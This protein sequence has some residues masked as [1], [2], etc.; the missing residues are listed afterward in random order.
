MTMLNTAMTSISQPKVRSL[1]GPVRPMRGMV[2]GFDV[3]GTEVE[4]TVS[5]I[6]YGQ[7]QAALSQS[8]RDAGRAGWWRTRS[9]A[10]R[11]R[12]G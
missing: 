6:K 3:E 4:I 1:R 7:S 9:P 12:S 2:L 5:P 8:A 11:S 10:A